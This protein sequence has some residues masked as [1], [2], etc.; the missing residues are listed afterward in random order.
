MGVVVH[1]RQRHRLG[2]RGHRAVLY[3]GVM[4]EVLFAASAFVGFA[5]PLALARR[6]FR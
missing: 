6:H 3:W 1:R 4:A 2:G 5:L